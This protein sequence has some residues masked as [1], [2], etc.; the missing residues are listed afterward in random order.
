MISTTLCITNRLKLKNAHKFVFFYG[1][2]EIDFLTQL[3]E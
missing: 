3:Y 2:F 1:S